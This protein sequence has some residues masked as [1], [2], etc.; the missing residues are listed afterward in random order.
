MTPKQRRF[1]QEY[2]IDG[3]G[4]RAA[5]RA[6]YSPRTAR[7]IAHENLTKP[8]IAEAI[9][10]EEAALAERTGITQ[11]WVI[12]NLKEILE[13]AKDPAV[14]QLAAANRASEL[15]GRH[16]GMFRDAEAQSSLP[17]QITRVTIVL[18]P[19]CEPPALEGQAHVIEWDR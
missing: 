3:N 15:I 13:I 9:S 10:R 4:S 1:V 11:E 18:P 17:V 2:P 7:S 6:G 19:G 14:V 16:L 12:E 5:I 8:A